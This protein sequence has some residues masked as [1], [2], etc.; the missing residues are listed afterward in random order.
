MIKGLFELLPNGALLPVGWVEGQ[1]PYRI[2]M[3]RSSLRDRIVDGQL[4][5]RPLRVKMGV[6]DVLIG[7]I[8]IPAENPRPREMLHPGQAYSSDVLAIERLI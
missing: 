7:Y 5:F 1:G 3:P 8:L 4:V 6:Q 2:F